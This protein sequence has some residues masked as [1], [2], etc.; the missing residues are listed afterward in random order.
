MY[1]D[2]DVDADNRNIDVDFATHKNE[3]ECATERQRGAREI[4]KSCKNVIIKR[5]RRL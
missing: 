5:R 4:Y 3:R 2:N 1:D